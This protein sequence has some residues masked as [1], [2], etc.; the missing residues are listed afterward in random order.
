MALL[1][2]S[3]SVFAGVDHAAV[4]STVPALPEKTRAVA[5]SPVTVGDDNPFEVLPLYRDAHKKSLFGN[6]ETGKPL[7][8]L[9]GMMGC[10]GCDKLLERVNLMYKSGQLKAVEP[11]YINIDWRRDKKDDP[12]VGKTIAEGHGFPQIVLFYKDADGKT[13]RTTIKGSR[14]ATEDRIL[15]EIK[16]A[17]ESQG[18]SK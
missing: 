15:F 18:K 5:P 8:V 1:W 13:Q 10:P 2:V 6:P 9:V 17:L 4:V 12:E 3:S 7:L 11:A 14:D 16:K